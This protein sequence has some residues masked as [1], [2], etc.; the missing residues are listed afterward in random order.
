MY[1]AKYLVRN[2]MKRID[3]EFHSTF[4][5]VVL[6]NHLLFMLSV[7]TLPVLFSISNISLLHTEF[8]KGQETQCSGGTL[9]KGR[10]LLSL[11]QTMLN[12]TS[13][14]FLPLLCNIDSKVQLL[15]AGRN[16]R[17]LP[18][19]FDIFKVTSSNFI[20]YSTSTHCL[21]LL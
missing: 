10:P 3:K 11:L 8:L 12:F 2:T 7:F 15:L 6:V 9:L 17:V 20:E 19:P 21:E 1:I 13:S 16:G 5:R 4:R 14:T 18:L